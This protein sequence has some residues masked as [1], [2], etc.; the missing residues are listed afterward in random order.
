[1]SGLGDYLLGGRERTI[2][3]DLVSVLVLNQVGAQLR[4]AGASAEM[5]DGVAAEEGQ[6]GSVGV[7]EFSVVSADRDRLGQRI[8]KRSAPLYPLG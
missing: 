4:G 3:T 5:L 6:G 7:L 1:M 2:D 8:K